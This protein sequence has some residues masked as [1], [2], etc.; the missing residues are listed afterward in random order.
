MIEQ[1]KKRTVSINKERL[2]YRLEEMSQFGLNKKTGGIDRQL[3]SQADKDTRKWL[4]NIWNNEMRLNVTVDAIANIWGSY[5]QHL[6]NRPIVFGSH[7]DSVPNGGRFDGALGVLIA[8]EAI[9]TIKENNIATQHPLEIISFTGEEPN[10]FSVSTLGSKVLC[11]RLTKKNIDLLSDKNT[12]KTLTETID[13]LGGSSQRIDE[14]K[15][16]PGMMTA[17]LEMHIEQGQC[18]YKMEKAVA[19]VNC[20]TG[21]YREIITVKGEANHAGTTHLQD[22]R[23]AL[24]AASE[25]C[26]AIEAIMKRLNDVSVTVGRIQIKPNTS[27]IIPG[28]AK[29]TIDMRT[30]YPGRKRQA[31]AILTEKVKEITDRRGVKIIR[32]LNLDQ[33]EMPMDKEVINAVLRAS[34]LEEQQSIQLVSM[35]GHDAANMARLTKTAMLFVQSVKGYSHCPEEYTASQEIEIAA[36]VYLDTL[37]IL[38]RELK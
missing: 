13:E 35:A 21:I 37:L 12:G 20:I 23:D 24:C 15:L 34:E 16:V 28:E 26:L 5:G 17:F 27:N 19:A 25:L 33:S 32:E 8:M 10:S 30:A 7:H 22:R 2:L 18:L 1:M 4:K 29:F 11:G 9:Q 31:L 36:Q 3:G 38:D 6:K 14:A